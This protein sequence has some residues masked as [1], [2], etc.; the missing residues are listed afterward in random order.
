MKTDFDEVR[1][2]IASVLA[3]HDVG[4]RSNTPD[5]LIAE[6]AV[7]A[8]QAFEKATEQRAAYM[9]GRTEDNV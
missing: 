8:I 4:A 1:K 6:L 2:D 5:I 9:N 7:F 3:K